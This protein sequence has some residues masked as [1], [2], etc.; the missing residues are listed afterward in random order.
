MKYSEILSSN[1]ELMVDMWW[2]KEI[3][4]EKVKY[5]N[6]LALLRKIFCIFIL[7]EQYAVTY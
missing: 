3:T 1:L 7:S 4:S 5:I 2:I 6:Y